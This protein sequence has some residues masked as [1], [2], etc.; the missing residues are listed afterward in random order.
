MA[1]QGQI[2]DYA[3]HTLGWYQ[4]QKLCQTILTDLLGQTVQVFSPGN[5]AGRDAAF[6]GSW[7]PLGNEDLSGSFT[8]QVKYSRRAEFSLGHADLDQ[9]IEKAKELVRLGLADNYIVITNHTYSGARDVDIQEWLKSEIGANRVKVYGADWISDQITSS[10]HLRMLVPRVYGLGDLSEILDERAYAQAKAIVSWMPALKTIVTT[11]AMQRAARVL[12]ENRFVLL[13]GDPMVGKSTAASSLALAALDDMKLRVLKVRSA[14]EFAEHWNAT[15]DAKQFFWVDD[16]F[17]ETFYD[18]ELS[19]DWGR[20][21][22]ALGAALEGGASV[23]M[24]SRSY[25][26][27]RAKGTIK[28]YAFEPFQTNKVV[29]RLADLSKLERQEM[30]YNHL[31]MG[32]QDLTLKERVKPLLPELADVDPFYPEAAR[33][34]GSSRYTAELRLDAHNLKEYFKNPNDIL[35][36]VLARLSAPEKAVLALIF[37]KNGQIECPIR[38]DDAAKDVVARFGSTEQEINDVI[39]SIEGVFIKRVTDLAGV[40]TY[41][42]VHPSLSDAMGTMASSR[43]EWLDVFLAGASTLA[44]LKQTHAGRAERGVEIEIPR[45]RYEELIGRIKVVVSEGYIGAEWTRYLAYRSGAAFLGAVSR[46][47]PDAFDERFYDEDDWQPW[48]DDYLNLCIAL[49]SY[50]LLS[51]IVRQAAVKRIEGYLSSDV[52]LFETGR[53]SKVL[54]ETEK[55]QVRQSLKAEPSKYLGAMESRLDDSYV[56]GSDPDDIYGEGFNYI[57][58]FEKAFPGDEKVQVACDMARGNLAERIDNR[59]QSMEERGRERQSVH[60]FRFAFDNASERTG[61]ERNIFSDVADAN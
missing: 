55:A 22:D 34:L 7:K 41:K 45:A 52:E 54:T 20:Y 6:S 37:A 53:F 19:R 12:R 32:D 46:Y 5:D 61:A 16:A 31:R 23:V 47:I 30:L 56:S 28:T 44:V 57:D 17:G 43:A 51:E 42:F 48:T 13:V 21:L 11:D 39:A 8:F 4:F 50:E 27:E 29:I 18:E 60:E 58:S 3:F 9:E 2:R 14:R 35:V 38:Y 33:R 40:I 1:V 26:W 49:Q 10:S 36:D 59:K 15:K 24:T 25:I